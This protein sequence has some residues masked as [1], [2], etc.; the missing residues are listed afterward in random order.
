MGR[1]GGEEFVILLPHTA[2]DEAQKVAERLRHE[3]ETAK[4]ETGKGPLTISLGVAVWDETCKNAEA[5]IER[6]D[7]ALYRAKNAGRNRVG[8]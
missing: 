4:T 7:Q 5:L 3:I 1:Y 2:I 8:V 6:A